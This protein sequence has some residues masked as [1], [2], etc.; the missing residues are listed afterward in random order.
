M[1]GFGS[2][3]SM[4]TVRKEN[5]RLR[6]SVTKYK[7][8]KEQYVGSNNDDSEAKIVPSLS[9]DEMKAGRKKALNYINRR[10]KMN[11][12]ILICVLIS[13][14]IILYLVYLGLQE[15][16]SNNDLFKLKLSQ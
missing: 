5:L 12:I 4:E 11:K 9:P 10:N 3:G 8:V 7:R 6:R 2:V 16:A 15:T 14:C 1:G 13:A